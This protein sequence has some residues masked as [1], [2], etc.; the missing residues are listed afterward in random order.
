MVAIKAPDNYRHE[1]GIIQRIGEYVKPLA[2]RVTILTSPTA[3]NLTREAVEASLKAAEVHWQ[4]HFLSGPCHLPTIEGLAEQAQRQRSELIVGIGGG[5]VLDSAKA[6]GKLLDDLSVITVPTIAATCAAW[7]PVTVLYNAQGGQDGHI[8]L[9]RFPQWVL[10][11]SSII[12]RAPVRFLRAGIVDA[13]AKWFEFAPYQRNGADDL[14]LTLKVNAAQL[15]FDT[16]R[17]IGE[18][19]VA[20]NERGLDTAALR[21]ATD[22]NIALAGLANSI[23][24]EIDRIGISHRIHDLLTHEPG[25]HHHW[26]HGEIVG[27]ALAVQSQL[28]SDAP[29]LRQTLLRL[30]Q[31]YHTPLTL[32]QL[33]VNDSPQHVAAI[34]QKF[35]L[36]ADVAARLPFTIDAGKLT[37]ALLTAAEAPATHT[38]AA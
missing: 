34:A 33:G 29:E 20:D 5:R 35:T 27:F 25:V 23:V 22:A 36:P 9:T 21:R 8:R 18:Q 1:A 26:L 37:H 24:D 14:G 3:W 11:D 7:S 38:A 13:L 17:D 15:A 19:A 16:L 4:V 28:D 31:Q 12:A 10:V 30:L 32:A 6:V 2:S